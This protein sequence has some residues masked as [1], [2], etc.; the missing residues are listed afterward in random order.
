MHAYWLRDHRRREKAGIIYRSLFSQGTPK[1]DLARRLKFRHADVR[2]MP[3][4]IDTPAW[5]FGYKDVTV[6]GIPA[7]K[8]VSI[9]IT[10]QEIAD[11]FKSYFEEFWKKSKPLK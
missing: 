6:I 10:S 8:P 5:F 7:K 9:E 4:M 1:R 2:Y 11:S 3:V